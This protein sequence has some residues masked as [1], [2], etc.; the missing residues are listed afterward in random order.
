M[1]FVADPSG[2]NLPEPPLTRKKCTQGY[3]VSPAPKGLTFEG[4]AAPFGPLVWEAYPPL[5][6]LTIEHEFLSE[7]PLRL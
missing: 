4:L 5:P 6:W 3:V 7:R 2:I 1:L